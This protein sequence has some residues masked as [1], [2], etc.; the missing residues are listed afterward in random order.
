MAEQAAV[1]REV[2]GSNPTGAAIHCRVDD[3]ESRCDS[4]SRR[5]WFD[6]N[7]GNQL[8]GSRRRWQSHLILAQDLAG[9]LREASYDSCLPS[10]AL[11]KDKADKL[12]SCS[13]IGRGGCLKNSLFC[14]GSTPVRSTN[15][16]WRNLVARQLWEL[17]VAG[18][19]PAIPT[20][21]P[22]DETGKRAGL[23]NQI[24][25]V[26]LPPR[27]LILPWRNW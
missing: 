25:W 16:M 12:C 19:N 23:R 26:R 15:G 7:L 18:S 4:E 1:N 14:T 24:L 27:V 9:T 6:P 17:K 2:V 22:C 20:I 5:C 3:L 11:T 13:P 21:C 10:S 8:L